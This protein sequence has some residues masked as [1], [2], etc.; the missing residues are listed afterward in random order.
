MSGAAPRG[1]LLAGGSGTRLRPL[2]DVTNKHLLPMYDRPLV[3]YAIETL[4]QAGVEEIM[5]VT[6]G[7]YAGGFLQL[8]GN[9]HDHGIGR[10]LYAYEDHTGG[11]AQVLHQARRFAAGGPIVV[12]LADN[13][14]EYSVG[15]AVEAFRR[16]PTGA[17]LLL[18]EVPDEERLRRLGV[19]VFDRQG[20]ISGIVEKPAD[21]P[22]RYAVTGLYCYDN[23]VFDVVGTHSSW[24]GQDLG[25]TGVNNHFARRGALTSS[26][27]HGFWRDAGESIEAYHEVN[28]LVRTY[29]ANKPAES[30]PPLPASDR[31][32]GRR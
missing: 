20:R 10:L 27:A 8:L 18:A 22:S 5:L 7:A 21:P 4:V 1:V 3:L 6:G 9:G 24:A 32:A 19:A 28:N 30:S 25:I 26:T 17:R 14:F 11:F 13:V 16:D 15:P 12:L 31:G 29:G 23:S 2:T